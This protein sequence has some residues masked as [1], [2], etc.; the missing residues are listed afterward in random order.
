LSKLY[1]Y[2]IV[3]VKAICAKKYP[4]ALKQN[5]MG[6]LEVSTE[7]YFFIALIKSKFV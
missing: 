4:T 3:W 7:L 1:L 2:A 5:Y 6:H